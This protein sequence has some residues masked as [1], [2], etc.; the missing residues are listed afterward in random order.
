MITDPK[1]DVFLGTFIL[2]Y[3]RQGGAAG[4]RLAQAEGVTPAPSSI[5]LAVS[6]RCC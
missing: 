3:L 4:V 6:M 2:G 5:F 1:G